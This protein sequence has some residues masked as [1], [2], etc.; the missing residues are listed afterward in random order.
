MMMTV[1]IMYSEWAVFFLYGLQFFQKRMKKEEKKST[2]VKSF[3]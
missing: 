1:V 3:F 2:D